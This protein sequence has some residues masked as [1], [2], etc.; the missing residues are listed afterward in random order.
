MDDNTYQ[1]K[2]DKFGCGSIR[3]VLGLGLQK[4]TEMVEEAIE[5]TSVRNMLGIMQHKEVDTWKGI[6]GPHALFVTSLAPGADK[7]DIATYRRKHVS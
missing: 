4:S 6:V 1:E 7:N 5:N 3:L 2:L